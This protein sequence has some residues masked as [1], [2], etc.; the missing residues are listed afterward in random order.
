MPALR[1]PI[2]SLVKPTRLKDGSNSPAAAK[3]KLLAKAKLAVAMPFVAFKIIIMRSFLWGQGRPYTRVSNL[4]IAT[5]IARAGPAVLVTG[6]FLAEGE[7]WK[8]CVERLAR[9]LR[10]RCSHLLW[11]EGRSCFRRA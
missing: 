1:L 6:T 7:S 10:S 3:T 8:A 4:A 2:N 5:D 9:N 11:P